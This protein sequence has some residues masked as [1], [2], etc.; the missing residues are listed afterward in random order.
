MGT[1]QFPPY[2]LRFYDP[3]GTTGWA[4]FVIARSAFSRPNNYVMANVLDWDC[5]E[6]SGTEL[7]QQAT[8]SAQIYNDRH[9]VIASEDFELTQ[10][11]GGDN[12]LSPVRMNAVFAYLCASYGATLRLQKR[13][14]RTSVT[15]TRLTM[16]GFTSPFNK[17]GTWTTTG[18]GKDAFAAMQHSLVWL[19]RVKEKSKSRPWRLENGEWDCAC[20]RGRKC[21]IRHLR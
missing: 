3:G 17:R 2:V 11:V 12:L 5:G 20:S 1:E 6:L 7:E 19:R 10:Q 14:M 18:K 16:A 8:A 4:R 15:V 9:G 21:D 13:S